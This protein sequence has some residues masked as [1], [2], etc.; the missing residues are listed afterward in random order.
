[1]IPVTGS[2]ATVLLVR[3]GLG[4]VTLGGI[5]FVAVRRRSFA[6]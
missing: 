6:A 3:I 1:V 4:L 2:D 5:L